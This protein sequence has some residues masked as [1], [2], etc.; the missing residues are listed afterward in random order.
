MDTR[1]KNEKIIKNTRWTKDRG[2]KRERGR[3]EKREFKNRPEG[4]REKCISETNGRRKKKK[5]KERKQN[6]KNSL[7]I[8]GAE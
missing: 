1:K 6:C 5:N 8:K 3:V 7:L 2:K 4:N